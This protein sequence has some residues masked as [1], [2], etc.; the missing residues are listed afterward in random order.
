MLQKVAGQGLGRKLTD[1]AQARDWLAQGRADLTQIPETQ[2]A[3][4]AALFDSLETF[5]ASQ[6][7][8]GAGAGPGGDWQPLTIAMRSVERQRR[9]PSNPFGVTFPQ[10][11]I[12]G[13]VGCLMS[14]ATALVLERV[15]GTM[16]RLR[17]SPMSTTQ[18]L[19]GKALAC[20]LAI[21]A[22]LSLL[23]AVGVLGFGLRPNS[24]ALLALAGVIAAFAFTGLMMLLSNLGNTVASVSGV[25]WAAMMPLMLF[26]GGM[27]PLFFMPQW[28]QSASAVSPVKW[29]VL[30]FEGAIWRDFSFAEML[31]PLAVLLGFGA[32]CFGLGARLM[33]RRFA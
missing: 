23:I 6:P 17:A 8:A 31:L 4:V 13:I 21:L 2:R 20:F 7:P 14:F 1:T 11:M 18:I 33:A 32:I 15:Q 24:P 26:G 30:A 12:W 27:I 19:L 25:G 28:M 22:M 29:A 3:S 5:V 16:Q 10:G 9:G